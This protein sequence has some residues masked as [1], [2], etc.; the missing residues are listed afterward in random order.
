MRSLRSKPVFVI[1]SVVVVASLWVVSASLARAGSTEM[2]PAIGQSEICPIAESEHWIKF[3]EGGTFKATLAEDV[4]ATAGAAY[5]SRSGLTTVPLQIRSVGGRSDVEGLGEVHFWLDK[6][7]PLTSAIW[8]KTAGTSFPAVQE[9]RFHFLI[10]FESMPGR[11][12]R[13]MDP[14]RM[15]SAEVQAFPPKPGTTYRLVSQVRL[16]DTA[17][18]GV[19]AATVLANTAAVGIKIP[20]AHFVREP[21]S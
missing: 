6:S 3:A 20:G 13:S 14:A 15:R 21:A 11:T 16:E 2:L 10:T 5:V 1:A 19:V 8:E 17:E 9:M 7:R 18:P 4:S 12:F